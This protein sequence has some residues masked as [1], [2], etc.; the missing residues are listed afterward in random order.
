MPPDAST[1]RYD[2]DMGVPFLL[3]DGYNLLHAAG[4]A[5]VRYAQGDLERARHRLLGML[6]EKLSPA[7]QMRATV[8]FDSS[9]AA[10]DASRE[11]R[12]HDVRVLFAPPGFEADDLIEQLIA[13]HPAAKQL[14][15]V[16]GD[17][18]LHKAANRRGATPVD[19]D[20]FW[21]RLQRRP[22]AR[23]SLIPEPGHVAPVSAGRVEE[24]GAARAGTTSAATAAW[25]AEF[26]EFSVEDLAAEVKAEDQANPCDPWRRH[27]DELEQTLDDPRRME[28]WLKESRAN[29]KSID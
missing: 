18:R 24:T 14:L 6:C 19:S 25:L 12:H 2:V 29:H 21:E 3:V 16:S 17:H 9:E 10:P 15:V 1:A 22:D 5:R 8:V 7:E 20:P 27:L 26:G 28:A 11:Q 4:L 13:Q 23:M